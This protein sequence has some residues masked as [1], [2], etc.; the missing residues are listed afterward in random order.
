MTG[1]RVTDRGGMMVRATGRAVTIEHPAMTAGR[2]MIGR[3]PAIEACAMIERP[4]PPAAMIFRPRW[5]RIE[6][7]GYP[8]S[9]LPNRGFER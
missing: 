9:N 6:D 3:L 7:G 5:R 4:E 2:A 8:F 1:G